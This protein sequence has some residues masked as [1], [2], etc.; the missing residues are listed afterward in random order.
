MTRPQSKRGVFARFVRFWRNLFLIVTVLIV[1][2][3]GIAV[4]LVYWEVTSTLPPVNQIV[5]YHA[6]VA[7][8]VF[9]D[10]GSLI[11]ELYVERRYLTPIEQIPTLVRNAFIAAE[12]DGFYRHGGVDVVSIGRAFVNNVISGAKVQGGSTITQ[13]V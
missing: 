11:G 1:L 9:A 2:G 6:P 13:Q 10:D 5:E 8:Q 4:G 7:T 3:V 12:D